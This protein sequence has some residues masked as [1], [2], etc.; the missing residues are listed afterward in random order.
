MNEITT[1]LTELN[2]LLR[3]HA[4]TA[5]SASQGTEFEY[6]R[7]CGLNQGLMRAKSV[8]ESVLDKSDTKTSSFE[9]HLRGTDEFV[10]T[11]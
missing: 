7:M 3:N 11:N 6:G 5:L 4:E 9:K 1:V 2:R 10:L 8:L